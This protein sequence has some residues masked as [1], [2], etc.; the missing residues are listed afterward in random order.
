MAFE[1]RQR[2]GWARLAQPTYDVTRAK[3]L[4]VSGSRPG[5][6]GE[7]GTEWGLVIHVLLE[8]AMERPDVDL[9]PLA[10][11]TL[12]E[13]ELDPRRAGEAVELV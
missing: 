12:R 2:E 5:H 8:A 4:A 9:A 6:P 7:H 13:Q 11:A 3:A 10:A 1:S